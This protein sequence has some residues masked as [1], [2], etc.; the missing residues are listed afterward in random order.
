MDL[1]EISDAVYA[2]KSVEKKQA[3]DLVY[4]EL[5]DF[6]KDNFPEKYRDFVKQ[7][8]QVAYQIEPEE[9]AQIVRS[10][11]PYGQRWSRD[12]IA[13]YI[14]EKGIGGH[15]T[16]Y[17]LVM[18]MMVN[19]Y[20]RTAKTIGQDDAEFYFNL[21]YDFINDEDGKPDKIARYFMY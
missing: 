6:M 3:M 10:M 7:A 9:A 12:D 17:Y 15:V 19:D 2:G 18:N 5:A 13:E 1:R 4:Y 20:S 21:A 16:D 14:Q 8:E 11:I